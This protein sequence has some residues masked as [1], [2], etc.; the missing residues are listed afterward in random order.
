M[1]FIYHYG[2]FWVSAHSH[3]NDSLFN[4]WYQQASSCPRISKYLG[5]FIDQCR[6]NGSSDRKKIML[7]PGQSYAN[8]FNWSTFATPLE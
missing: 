2:I 1:W 4:Y 6:N 7:G 3:V 5:V 8:L